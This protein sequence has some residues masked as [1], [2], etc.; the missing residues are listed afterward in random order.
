MKKKLFVI[1][2]VISVLLIV[3][4]KSQSPATEEPTKASQ[5]EIETASQQLGPTRRNY[6]DKDTYSS[7]EPTQKKEKQTVPVTEVITEPVTE[8]EYNSSSTNNFVASGTGDYVAE[9]LEVNEYGILNI[10]HRGSSNFVIWLYDQNNRRNL[11]V[12]TIGDYDGSVLVDHTGT[13]MLEIKADGNWSVNSQALS[14]TKDNNFYG[15]GDCVTSI[16]NDAKGSWK[17]T[18]N[19]DSNFIVWSYDVF[20]NKKDLLVNE[21]GSYSGVVFVK[22]NNG[23]IFQIISDGEWSINKK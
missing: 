8:L 15:K 12:N 19:G 18:N 20:T 17:I 23:T 4:C 2:V 13:Y 10:S 7:E 1:L 11:L 22:H 5:Q 16:L 6:F 21:I 9:G 14:L 3:G